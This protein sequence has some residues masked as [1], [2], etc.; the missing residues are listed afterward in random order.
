M[1]HLRDVA[2]MCV[3]R[4][5]GFGLLAIVCAMV[6]VSFDILL[7]VKTGA[8]GLSIMA[9]V[10]FLMMRSAKGRDVR[11]TE[12]WLVLEKTERPPLSVAQFV[13]GNV[14]RDVYGHFF[15]LSAAGAASLWAV[16]FGLIVL[17]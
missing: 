16:A 3:A 12:V 17:T 4:G 1:Q 11:R 10:L 5:C 13:I 7:A 2:S 15:R 9:A 8:I 14:L 6:G